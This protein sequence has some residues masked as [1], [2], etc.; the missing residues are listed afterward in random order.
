MS[1]KAFRFYRHA[2]LGKEIRAIGGFYVLL[3]EE[4]VAWQG[5]ELLVV[6]GAGQYDTSCCGTGGCG[7]AEVPGYIVAWRVDGEQTE[8]ELVLDAAEKAQIEDLV[9]K[10]EKVLSVR[11]WE[12]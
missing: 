9:K 10:R 2:E 5:R 3:K 6:I 11:F 7:Y 1:E 8:V 12:E 4:R